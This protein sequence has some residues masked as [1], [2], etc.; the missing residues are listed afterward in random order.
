MCGPHRDV[1]LV[2]LSQV[3]VV[4][5]FLYVQFHLQPHQPV[6]DMRD[7]HQVFAALVNWVLGIH[8]QLKEVFGWY[9]GIGSI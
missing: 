9:F 3:G 2:C 1:A 7:C 8:M 4:Q 6:R 5:C